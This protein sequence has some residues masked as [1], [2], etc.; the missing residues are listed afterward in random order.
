MEQ[1]LPK[2]LKSRLVVDLKTATL[3][4]FTCKAIQLGYSCFFFC[5]FFSL[6]LL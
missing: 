6:V 5:H 4:W 3:K 2:L 1:G